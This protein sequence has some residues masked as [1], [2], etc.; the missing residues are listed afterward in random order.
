MMLMSKATKTFKKENGKCNNHDGMRSI[1]LAH[2]VRLSTMERHPRQRRSEH[3]EDER[4]S[5]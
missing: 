3:E 4:C 5:V 2:T 1:M